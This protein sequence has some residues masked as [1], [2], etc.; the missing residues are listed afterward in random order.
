MHR[1]PSEEDLL[2]ITPH[3]SIANGRTVGFQGSFS[4]FFSF[5][6]R[7]SFFILECLANIKVEE[8]DDGNGD[9]FSSSSPYILLS[10][11]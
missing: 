5:P 10:N 9:L 11:L 7:V 6:Q 1:Q 3:D 4:F 8:E 2:E